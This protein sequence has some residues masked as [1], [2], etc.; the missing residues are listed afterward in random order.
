MIRKSRGE[1]VRYQGKPVRGH[2]I[3]IQSSLTTRV[4]S[5]RR[6]LTAGTR[7]MGLSAPLVVQ[8]C[9]P[10]RYCEYACGYDTIIMSPELVCGI[11]TRN[12]EIFCRPCPVGPF[13]VCHSVLLEG[14]LI[15][16]PLVEWKHKKILPLSVGISKSFVQV[17][18]SRALYCVSECVLRG[19]FDFSASCGV[20]A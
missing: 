11:Q 6:L 10:A 20:E 7:L 4:T 1:L 8:W 19:I 15:F 13:I 5:Y 18:P 16:L 12:L 3:T 2:C 14:F 17:Q 9:C